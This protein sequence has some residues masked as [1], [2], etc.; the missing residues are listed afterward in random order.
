MLVV[1]LGQHFQ[2]PEFFQIITRGVV[3]LT[4]NSDLFTHVLD[5]LTILIHST[6]INDRENG[7]SSEETRKHY[8]YNNLVKKLKKEI[9]DKTSL[10]IQ[11]LR[12]LLPFPKVMCEVI[13]TE[14]FGTVADAKGN[15]TRGLH[16]DKK[17]GLQVSDKQKISPWDLLEGHKNPAPLSWSWFGAVKYERKTMRYEEFFHELKYADFSHLEKP[18][19]YFLEAPP[20]PQEELEPGVSVIKLVFFVTDGG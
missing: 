16:S 11:Y 10:S 6:Q 1:D 17:Q 3:D 7:Q 20:L 12:Q 19:E 14:P 15:K 4:N 18:K 13:V 2:S 8:N 5:I 9:G